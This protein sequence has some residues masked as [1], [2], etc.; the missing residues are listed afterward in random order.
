MDGSPPRV[1]TDVYASGV[2]LYELL[3]GKHPFSADDDTV[4]LARVISHTPPPISS[5]RPEVPPE[6]DAILSRAIS[7][8]R[9]VRFS[10][11]KEF[12]RELRRVLTLPETEAATT[13]ASLAKADY[14]AMPSAGEL[15]VIPLGELED[16]WRNPPPATVELR[17]SQ[18][19]RSELEFAPTQAPDPR[20]VTQDVVAIAPAPPKR[21]VAML[22][23]VVA[24]VMLAAGGLIAGIVVALR[25]PDPGEEPKLILIEHG[26]TANSTQTTSAGPTSSTVAATSASA[27]A[28]PASVATSAVKPTAKPPRTRSRAPS[29]KQQPAIESCFREQAAA[30]NGTP[31]ISIKFSVDK[32]GVVQ[33]ADMS[34]ADVASG[35]LGQCILGVAK[36]TQFAP[37]RADRL[38]NPAPRP[39]GAVAGVAVRRLLLPAAGLVSVV[40]CAATPPQGAL[41]PRFVAVHNALAAMGMAEVGAV[42]TDRWGRARVRF[43]VDLPSDCATVIALGSGEVHDLDL[44]VLDADDKS[45]GRDATTDSQ[46]TVKICPPHGGRFSLVVRMKK[47]SGDSVVASWSGAPNPDRGAPGAAPALLAAGTCEAPVPLLAGLFTGNTRRGSSEHTANNCGNTDAKELVYRIDIEKR[48]RVL[49]DVN[50][51]FDSV[52]YVRKDDCIDQESQIACNDDAAQ[53]S[54][55]KTTHASRIEEVFEPGTYFVFVDGYQDQGGTF[56]MKV[57]IADVPSLADECRQTKPLVQR[58]AG[59]LT[60][61]FDAAQ[62][63]CDAGK[64]P[65]QSLIASTSR[66]APAPGSSFTPTTSLRACISGR[67]CTDEASELACSDSGMKSADAALV[68]MLDA[69]TYTLFADS[70]ERGQHGRYTLDVDLTNETGRGVRGD[71]CADAIPSRRTTSRSRETPSRR[72]TTSRGPAPARTP[73]T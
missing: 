14:F 69:G 23:V 10:S 12:A 17:S 63:A 11:A 54:S 46:A 20:V 6:L 29:A 57:E 65:G 7:K 47:G 13:L 59:T 62:G 40:A 61:S 50:P 42:Q 26:A 33:R 38:H 48:S 68:T 41:E 43:S 64:G 32:D 66:R 4:T 44:E 72:R 67:T 28:P 35:P 71:A 1:A 25:R 55:R 9:S 5:L 58:A 39:P 2:T 30:V 18:P 22:S 16:A 24:G 70:G 49:L 56:K 51:S 36:Q 27:E 3:A 31:E 34:P 19:S 53:T 73:P 15:G 21:S 60:G 37:E 52:L 45:V 8:D